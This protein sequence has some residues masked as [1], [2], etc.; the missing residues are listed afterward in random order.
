[1]ERVDFDIKVY[2]NIIEIIP[3]DGVQNNSI[4]E[5]RLKNLRSINGKKIIDKKTISICT[6]LA[7]SYCSLDSVKVL[8]A[9]CNI[10]DKEILFHI[11]E[12]S[13]VADYL[14]QGSSDTVTYVNNTDIMIPRIK[15]QVNMPENLNSEGIPFEV[16]EYVKYKA[17]KD[18]IIKFYVGK[19]ALAGEKGQLGDIQFEHQSKLPDISGLL[20]EFDEQINFWKDAV[21]GFGIEGRAKPKATLHGRNAIPLDIGSVNSISP[22]YLGFDRG[23]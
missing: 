19:A 3:K 5:V 2:D 15:D 11:R 9:D 18:C 1:M 13:K 8:I 4:Y 16:S 21:R 10:P 6:A 22:A 14:R 20:K 17:A 12:A 23:V 7:P